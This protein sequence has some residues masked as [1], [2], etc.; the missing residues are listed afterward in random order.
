[1]VRARPPLGTA[2]STHTSL[3]GTGGTDP[4]IGRRDRLLMAVV[5][6][7]WLAERLIFAVP[8]SPFYLFFDS[9]PPKK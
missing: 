1:M 8:F 4:V 2:K 3:L 9:P 6:S 7:R 5:A